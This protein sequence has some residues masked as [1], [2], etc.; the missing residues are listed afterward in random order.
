MDDAAQELD[1]RRFDVVVVGCGIAGL[2]AAVTARQAGA[3]TAVL[4]RSAVE[5]RGG[6]T[7]WTEAMMRMQSESAVAH[8]F[9]EH[10]AAN[11]GHY[12][13]PQLINEAAGSFENWP[14]IVKVLN[15][16]D[17]EII[18]TLSDQA[19]PTIAWLKNFGVRFDFLPG[20]FLTTC[21]TRLAP[22]GGGLAL[23]ETL[24]GWAEQNGV[25]FFY[26]TTARD[27]LRSDDGAVEGVSALT[28][29]NSTVLFKAPS[30]VL[31]SGGFEGNPEM[32]TRYLGP[33]ARY[34]RPVAR[35]GY[36]NR[37][38]GIQMALG[39][40]AA[41]AGDFGQIHAEPLD[42]R[43]GAPEPIVLV[44][45]YGILVNKNGERF[46]D[47]A[48]A[49]VDATYEAITRT[50]LEQREGIAWAIFDAKIDEVPNWKRSVRSDQ[51]PISAASIEELADLLGVDRDALRRTID[52]YNEACTPGNFE[53]LSLDGLSTRPGYAPKKSNW[54]RRIDRAPF[55]AYPI[56][57]GNCF[58]FGGIRVNHG[59]EVLSAGG[60]P[61]PGLYAAGEM[62]GI[63]YGTYTGATS[64]LRGAVFG[65][66]AGKAAAARA[67]KS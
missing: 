52:S 38:E 49:T 5:D 17:P 46:I 39:A 7:R 56:I 31:A 9:E 25:E 4:E 67:A 18:S 65:R 20:Y 37:G 33:R 29:D 26:R 51:P 16:T 57:C 48:P 50:I 13:D 1:I 40:G 3:R 44:F 24:A 10:F 35:G 15:F 32:L 6:Q 47:E 43:S 34:L 66:I 19:G 22:I 21:T 8:D 58:T 23:V 30:V 14:A 12:L 36:Y 61:I 42:P 41:S 2:A 59:S 53:P 54:A 62:T 11:S 60:A 55:L 45:N 63:Y 27:L 28:A 64:V